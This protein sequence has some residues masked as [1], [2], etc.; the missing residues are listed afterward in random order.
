MRAP[1]SHTPLFADPKRL[2]LDLA[3]ERDLPSLLDLLVSRIGGSDAVALVRLWLLRPGEGCETC[4]LRSECPDR[5]QCLHLVASNGR[6]KASG[7]ADLTRLDGRYRRFPVGVRKV[8]M[9]ALKGEAVEAPDLAVMPEWIADPAWIRA[10]GVTGFAGQPLS[11]Q[12]MVLG[13]LG[14]FS[15]V[16]I[17]VER[18]DWLRMIA[19]HAA[20]AIAHSYAWNEVERLRARLEE[21]NEYLQEEVALEQGFGEMLGTSPALAN[22]GSQ[23]NLVAPTTSTV[24]V[25]GESGVGK[26]LVARELHKRSG[27]ADRPLIK[28]NCAA[29]PRELFE[30]EFFGHVKGAFTGALRDRVG[31]FELANGGTLF[32]DEVG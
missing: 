30:S 17:D 27:R 6:S 2:L 4:L 11:H 14:V 16:K 12:G 7:G 9:I 22:V 5:S 13:V 32:L 10:E 25:L 29:V 15:R 21:E 18:L 23:I 26:E 20:V 1:A 19:D 31:R 3:Q 24:L 28:V 8:G